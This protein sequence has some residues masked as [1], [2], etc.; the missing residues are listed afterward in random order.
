MRKRMHAGGG[1]MIV[2]TPH[3]AA[4]FFQVAFPG[5]GKGSFRTRCSP[6]Q[7]PILDHNKH[8]KLNRFHGQIW[9]FHEHAK[10]AGCSLVTSFSS[11]IISTIAV[12]S[13]TS[14][15]LYT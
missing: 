15:N 8:S 1:F 9:G 4:I 3:L 11:Y 14:I 10:L 5:T 12:K 2:A 6:N 13:C 7:V